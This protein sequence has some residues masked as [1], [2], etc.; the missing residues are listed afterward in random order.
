MKPYAVHFASAVTQ[1][2]TS[3][4]FSISPWKSSMSIFILKNFPEKSEENDIAAP[5]K[6]PDSTESM[7]AIFDPPLT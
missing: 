6:F 3:G 2:S 1:L 4:P 5:P 7:T